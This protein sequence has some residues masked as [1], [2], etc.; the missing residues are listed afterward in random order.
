MASRFYFDSGI[1]SIVQ[2]GEPEFLVIEKGTLTLQEVMN[3]SFDASP[4][5]ALIKIRTQNLGREF[6]IR[7][8]LRRRHITEDAIYLRTFMPSSMVVYQ[9]AGG[10]VDSSL[11]G[12]KEVNHVYSE[13]LDQRNVKLFPFES[14]SLEIYVRVKMTTSLAPTR[15]FWFEFGTLDQFQSEYLETREGRDLENYFY[16]FFCGLMI[17]QLLYVLLQ[18]YLVRK[19]EYVNYAGYIL[20]VFF[21]FY[22]R[23]SVFNASDEN[24]A[25]V[26]ASVMILVN[27]PLLVL[28]SYFY[29]RFTRYFVDLKSRDQKLC[30]QIKVFEWFLLICFLGVVLLHNIPNDLNK[31]IPVTAA[32]ICQIPFASYALVRIYRQRRTIAYFLVVAS[33]IAL[34]SHLLANFLPILYPN[35][36]EYVLPL[37]ITMTG[38]LLEVG[39]FNT[40][41]LFK[42]RESETEKVKAQKALLK[43]STERRKLQEEY[44][45]VR[46]KIS[47]DLHDDLGSSLS[48]IQI[49]GYAARQKL[50]EEDKQQTIKLLSNIEK[51]SQSMLNS[52][53]DIV[54][55]INPSND[56][57][58]KLIERI[59][60]FAFEILSARGVKFEMDVDS[61]FN[62][63]PLNQAQRRNMLLIVK[64]AVNNAAKYSGA[65]T[66]S[67]HVVK[68]GE[69]FIIGVA[70]NGKG[71][72][73]EVTPG[74]GMR[75]MKKR[76]LELSNYFDLKSGLSGTTIAFKI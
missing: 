38:V 23:F 10:Q 41:L 66:V 64:E 70:D 32:L 74:N 43:E 56:N 30:R 22:A 25:Y 54:W 11:I 40:G 75:T 55:A 47:G 63:H 12:L 58:E 17:F 3:A 7:F 29:F 36:Y 72:N 37:Q 71:F 27:S 9:V 67:F 53:S 50:E 61:D 34:L 26:S 59:Q 21:Y 39:L 51:T 33:S 1:D 44:Y 31:S 45:E 6:W 2:V 8:K 18:C 52:M 57:N 20:S 35:I 15:R 4:S 62:S 16:A 60:A 42:A 46:D 19:P 73:E 5:S 48:S 14:D 24:L 49:Y 13:D 68:D 69:G 65:T 28:P 76:A